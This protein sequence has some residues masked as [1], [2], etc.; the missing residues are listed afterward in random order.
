MTFFRL[1]ASGA[2]LRISGLLAAVLLTVTPAVWADVTGED[3]IERSVALDAGGE[4]IVEATNG[5]I[6]VESWDGADVQVVAHKKARAGDTDDA[7][8]LLA[9]T[10]VRI[11]ERGS[12]VRISAETP[13]GDGGWFGGTS[14]SVSFEIKL[15]RD[16]ELDA[17]SENGSIEV[18]ELGAPARLETRNGSI[19]AKGVGGPL[20]AESSNGSIKAYDVQGPI[21]AETTNGSIKA[22][23]LGTDLGSGMRL[24]TTNGTV[25]LRIDA[26]IAASIAARTHNGTVSSDF[27]GGVQDRRKRS[28]DLDLG[29]GGPQIE[30]KSSNGSIRVRER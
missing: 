4:V 3:T 9:R 12:S 1:R 11:E 25:E 27:E 29:G 18:R 28:L 2:T 30:L 7:F 8:D 15:P 19:T 17:S 20:E 10:E 22:E 14:V 16:A 13:R 23:I 24:A 6:H 21:Q 5:S 26:G